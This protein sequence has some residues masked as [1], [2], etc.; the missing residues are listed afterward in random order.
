MYIPKVIT[1]KMNSYPCLDINIDSYDGIT[2]VGLIP[3]DTY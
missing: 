1:G 2:N 3:G